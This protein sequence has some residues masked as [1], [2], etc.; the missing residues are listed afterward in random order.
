MIFY[1]LPI[2]IKNNILMND[3]KILS[4]NYIIKTINDIPLI[5]NT[6]Y[7][8]NLKNDIPFDTY[9]LL[10]GFKSIKIEYYKNNTSNKKYTTIIK[11]K[12]F[13][14]EDISINFHDR[15]INY[16]INSILFSE[17]SEEILLEMHSHNIEIPTNIYDMLYSNKKIIFIR[18]ILNTELM[19]RFI[20]NN[21]DISKK[22]YIVN[23]ISGKYLYEFKDLDKFK[24][25]KN[26]TFELTDSNMDNIKIKI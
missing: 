2:I 5:N 25:Y 22:L 20:K 13:R 8:T 7:D 14:Y 3:F 9:L 1:Y 16:D 12:I 17:L 19:N 4:K 26:I 10:N 18:N 21:I 23:K 24:N 15:N 6:I 11:L